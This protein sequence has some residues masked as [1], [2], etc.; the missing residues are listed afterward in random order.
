MPPSADD[1]RNA[2]HRRLR[3]ATR[4][5]KLLVQIR[6]GDLHEVELPPFGGIDEVTLEALAGTLADAA[7]ERCTMLAIH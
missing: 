4:D 2:L 3:R 6:A 1:F 5:G 7:P